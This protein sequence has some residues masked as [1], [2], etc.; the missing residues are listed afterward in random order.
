MGGWLE[1]NKFPKSI[2]VLFDSSGGWVIFY[3]KSKK[4]GLFGI[5]V[6]QFVPWTPPVNSAVKI[7]RLK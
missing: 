7:S 1:K 2:L 4:Y 3:T 5:Y 6:R